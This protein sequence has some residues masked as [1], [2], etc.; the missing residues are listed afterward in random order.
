M[1][2]ENLTLDGQEHTLIQKTKGGKTPKMKM[3]ASQLK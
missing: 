3:F 2:I 1:T